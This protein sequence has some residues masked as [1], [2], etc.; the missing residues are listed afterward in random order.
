MN[1]R[2]LLP[3][4]CALPLQLF[5][6]TYNFN[7]QT[8]ITFENEHKSHIDTWQIPITVEVQKKI[9]ILRRPANGAG[10]KPYADTLK[11]RDADKERR[12][13]RDVFTKFKIQDGRILLIY[14]DDY[15][16]MCT[17][18]TKDRKRTEYVFYNQAKNE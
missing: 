9:I 13:K 7:R 4:I 1:R 2:I 8:I 17:K 6:Q 3:L 10:E 14:G 18:E 11:I 12:D 15:M 5:S 16:T